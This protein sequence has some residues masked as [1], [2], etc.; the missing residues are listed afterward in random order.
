ML[1]IEKSALDVADAFRNP[2]LPRPHASALEKSALDVADTCRNR[3]FHHFQGYILQI[4][5]ISRLE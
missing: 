4:Y 2:S 5:L 3:H 1:V